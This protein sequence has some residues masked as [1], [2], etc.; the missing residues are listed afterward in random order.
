MSVWCDKRL[1]HE[2]HITAVWYFGTC[3]RNC[4]AGKPPIC[5]HII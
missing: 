1:L 5:V 3:H 2:F 4:Q